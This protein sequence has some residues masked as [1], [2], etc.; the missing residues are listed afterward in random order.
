MFFF[1][2]YAFSI[3]EA[4]QNLSRCFDVHNWT[5][6]LFNTKSD[7]KIVPHYF[8]ISVKLNRMIV[9]NIWNLFSSNNSV[10]S[11]WINATFHPITIANLSSLIECLEGI[12]SIKKNITWIYE[13]SDNDLSCSTFMVKLI[14]STAWLI[15]IIA[16]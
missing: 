11:T 13:T 1:L 2:L 10:A 8:L 14:F 7:A 15:I 3:T 4:F 16:Q 12:I 5:V 9:G 6:F